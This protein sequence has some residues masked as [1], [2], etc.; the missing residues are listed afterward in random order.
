MPE[1][2]KECSNEGDVRLVTGSEVSTAHGRG[3]VEVCSS[4]GLWGTVCN[5]DWSSEDARV[6]C[7]GLGFNGTGL[8][9]ETNDHYVVLGTTIYY[10]R[11]TL[12][13][14][15]IQTVWHP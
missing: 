6:V 3:R 15:V 12:F 10:G 9:I 4:I 7:R 14:C 1:E 5:N 11:E 8:C 13:C 2:Q